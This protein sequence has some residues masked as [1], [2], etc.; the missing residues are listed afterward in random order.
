MDGKQLGFGRYGIKS[1]KAGHLSNSKIWV[2][3]FADISITRKR[4]DCLCVH[5][6]NPI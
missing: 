5:E 2:R 3:V 4:S 6:T 1:C